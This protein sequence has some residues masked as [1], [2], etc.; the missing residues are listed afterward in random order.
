MAKQETTSRKSKVRDL[1]NREGA[2]AAFVLGTKLKLKPSTLR[3]WI[4]TWRR[5]AAKATPKPPAKKSVTA[6]TNKAAAAA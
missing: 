1:Y 4:G 5:D 3:T 6:A 2:E